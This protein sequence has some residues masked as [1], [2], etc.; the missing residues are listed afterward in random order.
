MLATCLSILY[1][2]FASPSVYLLLTLDFIALPSTSPSPTQP[3]SA[4]PM[5][6]MA[7]LIMH[8]HVRIAL[9]RFPLANLG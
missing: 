6:S 4:A 3:P 5:L 8:R 9:F 1:H 7:K 2:S